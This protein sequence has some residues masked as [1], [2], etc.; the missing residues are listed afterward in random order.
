MG[1]G[2]EISDWDDKM[3]REAQMG[4]FSDIDPRILEEAMP[5]VKLAIEERC[6]ECL[7]ENIENSRQALEERMARAGRLF[8]PLEK[9]DLETVPTDKEYHDNF[10]IAEELGFRD[11]Q[12]INNPVVIVV[13]DEASGERLE[14]SEEFIKEALTAL[15]DSKLALEFKDCE[16]ADRIVFIDEQI[17]SRRGNAIKGSVGPSGILKTDISLDRVVHIFR[18]ESGKMQRGKDVQRTVVHELCHLNLAKSKIDGEPSEFA[19][20]FEENREEWI[21]ASAKQI[22]GPGPVSPYAL[23]AMYSVPPGLPKEYGYFHPEFI[24]ESVALWDTEL[25]EICPEL[26]KFFND[27]LRS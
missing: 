25:I 1:C 2:N 18:N 10:R 23:E 22:A 17:V 9:L 26:D 7:K 11:Y 4:K 19:K 21:I 20:I 3:V 5:A 27:H 13:K 12:I 8:T 16:V 24:A 15:R 6:V 14:E